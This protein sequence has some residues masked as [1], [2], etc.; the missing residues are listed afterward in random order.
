MKAFTISDYDS[1]NTENNRTTRSGVG[2]SYKREFDDFFDL[3]NLKR[4]VKNADT[5]NK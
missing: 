2:I 4:K 5:E 1:Y 3:F